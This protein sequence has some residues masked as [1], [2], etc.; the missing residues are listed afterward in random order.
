V[1]FIGWRIYRRHAVR[2]ALVFLVAFGLFCIA[3]DSRAAAA[4]HSVLQFAE[5]IGPRIADCVAAIVL[6]T[7]ALAIQLGLGGDVRALRSRVDQ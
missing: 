4:E 2:G 6:M 1:S 7:I 5:G 3:R